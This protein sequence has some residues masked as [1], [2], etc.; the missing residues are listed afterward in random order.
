MES[1][2][3]LRVGESNPNCCK[4]RPQYQRSTIPQLLQR[5]QACS[6]L[7]AKYPEAADGKI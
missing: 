5:R 2:R 3:V 7:K 4:G 1:L 6:F